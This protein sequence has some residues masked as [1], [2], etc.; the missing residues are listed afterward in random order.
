MTSET[1]HQLFFLNS[2]EFGKSIYA[3]RKAERLDINATVAQMVQAYARGTQQ[4]I[5]DFVPVLLDYFSSKLYV[6][7]ILFSKP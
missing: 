3:W 1:L 7:L 2:P 5:S 4:T 6:F